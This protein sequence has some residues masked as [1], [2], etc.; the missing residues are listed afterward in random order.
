MDFID[1]FRVYFRSIFSFLFVIQP[2]MLLM[3]MR[4]YPRKQISKQSQ[5]KFKQAK[6]LESF[7]VF[8]LLHF[9]LSNILSFSHNFLLSYFKIS[10]ISLYI[11]TQT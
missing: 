7:I 11:I 5:A 1:L 2:A 3:K 9:I 8:C 10:R 6:S 4:K